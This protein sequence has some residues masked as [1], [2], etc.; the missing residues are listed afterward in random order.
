MELSATEIDELKTLFEKTREA[1]DSEHN[2]ANITKWERKNGERSPD[3][4][5]HIFLG[6]SYISNA[7]GVNMHDYYFD[8]VLYLVTNLRVN[9]MRYEKFK[10]DTP[11]SKTI[12]W[13]PGVTMETSLFGIKTIY[14]PDKE[15][16]ESHENYLIQNY[17]DLASLQMPDFYNNEAMRYI[18]SM[19]QRLCEITDK[20]APDFSI[21]FPRWR[22]SPF[23]NACS[24]RG[25]Q[26]LCTDFYDNP[27]F[28]HDLM[29]FVTDSRIKWEDSCTKFLGQTCNAC[30]LA[31]DEVNCPVVSPQQYAQFIL[32]YEKRL[33]QYYGEFEYFHSCGNLTALIPHIKTLE[34]NLFQVSPWTDPEVACAAFSNTKTVLDIWVNVSGDIMH[35]SPDHTIQTMKRYYEI[36]RKA[37]IAGFQF[38]SG[39]LQRMAQSL[40]VDDKKISHWAQ[41]CR[42]AK[43]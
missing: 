3:G 13:N 35:A 28:V 31:N 26:Q 43:N 36:C 5:F 39:N 16:W 12:P 41:A 17:S 2:L 6:A 25:M 40:D 4:A 9:L 34:P 24:L 21:S 29:S 27:D 38:N 22:R 11:L 10:D 33:I 37:D 7:L 8:P 32:P 30:T 42:L 20:I 19:Y 15:A 14:Q 18:Q 1:Y 23:G